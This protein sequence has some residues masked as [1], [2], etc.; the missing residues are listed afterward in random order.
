MTAK[1]NM[2]K[3]VNILVYLQCVSGMWRGVFTLALGEAVGAWAAGVAAQP[4]HI[5]QAGT[6]TRHLVTAVK[7]RALPGALTR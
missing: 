4:H 7:A 3:C 5:G 1:I 2:V 6:L